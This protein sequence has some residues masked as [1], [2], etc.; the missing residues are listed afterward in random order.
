LLDRRT[1]YAR[2]VDN[3]WEWHGETKGTITDEIP[4]RSLIDAEWLIREH[5]L[6][7][8]LVRAHESREYV[9]GELV[10]APSERT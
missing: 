2:S 3:A 7:G 10:E 8:T 4:S 6:T 1:V 5:R 9:A